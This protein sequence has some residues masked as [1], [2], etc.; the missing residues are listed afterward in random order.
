MTHPT[1]KRWRQYI[2]IRGD[3]LRLVE[4]VTNI[5]GARRDPTADTVILRGDGPWFPEMGGGSWVALCDER[6]PD[7]IDL[8]DLTPILWLLLDAALLPVS[9]APRS[10]VEAWLRE[11]SL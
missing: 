2:S 3:S 5:A 4:S 10:K 11:I 6:R 8:S 9:D 7:D 1:S